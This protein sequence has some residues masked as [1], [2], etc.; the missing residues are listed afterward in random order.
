MSVSEFLDFVAFSVLLLLICTCLHLLIY[1]GFICQKYIT[2]MCKNMLLL[3]FLMLLTYLLLLI[4]YN[5]PI[6]S[7]SDITVT[8][9]LL[10]IVLRDCFL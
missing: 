6:L 5:I 2:T 7:I 3:L 8:T 4:V 9:H 1:Q 10:L